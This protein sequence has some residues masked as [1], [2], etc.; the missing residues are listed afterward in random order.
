MRQKVCEQIALLLPLSGRTARV[1]Q[2]VQNGFMGAYFS[3]ISGLDEM[4]SIRVYDVN[5]EGGAS[6]AYATAVADG[7]QFVIGPLLRNSV[8]ALANDIL[9]PVPIL[10]LN[11]LPDD[12]LAPPGL[13]QF[14]LAPEDEASSAAVRAFGDGYTRAVALVPE[15]PR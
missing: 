3:A 1:G 6:I 10:T 4:Q 13:Y 8:I 11:Y 5:A 9:V 14:A 2:A 7:A 15:G 12:T